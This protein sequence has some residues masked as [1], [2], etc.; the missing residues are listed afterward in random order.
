MSREES[1]RFFSLHSPSVLCWPHVAD[2]YVINDYVFTTKWM[3]KMVDSCF[4]DKAKWHQIAKDVL[5]M[6]HEHGAS[7]AEVG[8]SVSDGFS[9]NVRLGEVET[10]EYHRDKGLEITVYFG[11]QVGNS[12]TTDV[13]LSAV[14]S[15]VKAACTIA[16]ATGSDPCHGLADPAMLA[17]DPPNLNLYHPWSI[18]VSQGIE[19]VTLCEESGRAFDKRITNSEGAGLSTYQ[20]FYIYANSNNFLESYFT[21]RHSL[22]CSLLAELNGQKQRDYEYTVARAHEDLW[23]AQQVGEKAAQKTIQRLNSQRLTTRRTP[24]IFASTV[25]GGLIGHFVSAIRGSNLYRN[26]SFLIDHL[27]KKIFPDN[28]QITEQPHLLKGLGSA[29]FD[30]E[31][32]A[33][34]PRTI[35]KDG[36]LQNYILDSYSARKLNMK[37]T[38]NAGGVHN[39]MI[40]PTKG[41]LEELLQEMDTGLLITELMGQGINIITGDYSRGAAGF[42]VEH[43]KIQFP[44][45]EITVAGNLRDMFMQLIGAGN[46][47]DKRGNIC[48]GSLLIE[49]MTVAGE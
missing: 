1:F 19:L 46:D 18:E 39:L 10:I 3:M 38:G 24:V 44:V 43:G 12:S 15:A 48:S 8:A 40:Q 9:L 11:Q 34:Q 29:P 41:S 33:T 21:S 4:V 49:N 17:K 14:R 7:S 13:S 47:V 28:I 37:T 32:V 22:N 35:I 5:K 23:S 26:A 45:H 31:G 2:F 30:N 16:K 42:W 6:A 25:A 36:I 27:E 20:T